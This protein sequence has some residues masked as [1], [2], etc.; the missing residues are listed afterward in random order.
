MTTLIIGYGNRSRRDDGVGWFVLEQLAAL[1]LTGVELESGH[2]LT[3]EVAE[4]LSQC[5]AAIFVDAAIPE[6]PAPVSRSEV[7]P[8]FQSHAVAHYL[9]PADVLSLCQTLYGRAPRATLFSI[10]GRDFDFGTTLSPEVEQA[11]REVVDQI[12]ELVRQGG[13]AS[14]IT[15]PALAAHN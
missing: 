12:V 2:Q 4:T 3:V 15:A 8:R 5:D 10:R 9:T 14:P 1:D 13:V 6:A 11:A 7:A